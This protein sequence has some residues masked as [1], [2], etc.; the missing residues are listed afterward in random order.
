MR[1]TTRP[2]TPVE[3]HQRLA[4][5]LDD[6]MATVSE[7]ITSTSAT[8]DTPSDDF[9]RAVDIAKRLLDTMQAVCTPVSEQTTAT[10][11]VPQSR[12]YAT[13]AREAATKDA[14]VRTV[15]PTIPNSSR[16]TP[17]SKPKTPPPSDK[18]AMPSNRL[19]LRFRDPLKTT[20]HP[21][22]ICEALNMELPRHTQVAG[23]NFSRGGNLV[24]HVL[25]PSSAGLLA[26]HSGVIARTLDRVLGVKPLA[27]D[28]GE[29]WHHIVCHQ[30]P[31]PHH[32]RELLTAEIGNELV[33]WNKVE[34]GDK[35]Y[36][37]S[38]VLCPKEDLDKRLFVTIKITLKN[39]ESARRLCSQGIFLF[40]THCRV[41]TYRHRR[42]KA[43]DASIPH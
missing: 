24:L 40:G 42:A 15:G 16:K 21:L 6:T 28:L 35:D 9:K 14:E 11:T 36:V 22:L 3:A 38:L 39:E 13:A 27:F 32:R 34:G 43:R 26:E 23:V 19:V 2:H 29:R 8:T 20:L 33:E 18:S 17:K 5:L 12:T 30:V 7:I 37:S 4:I 41:A 10:K 25:A 1:Q 31:V